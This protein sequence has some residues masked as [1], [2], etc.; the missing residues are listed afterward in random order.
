MEPTELFECIRSFWPDAVVLKDRSNEDGDE[1][2]WSLVHTYEAI[3]QNIDG[4]DDWLVLGAWAFHQAL[5]ELAL[6]KLSAGEQVI[7]PVS[8]SLS[9]FDRYMRANLD[10]DCWAIERQ[11]YGQM[12]D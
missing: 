1:P 7:R 12:E 9:S 11:K 2:L 4:E 10:D 8:V 3:E 6:L 5:T